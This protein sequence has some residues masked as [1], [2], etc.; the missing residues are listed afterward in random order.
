MDSIFHFNEEENQVKKGELISDINL[1]SVRTGT[2][3]WV[4]CFSPRFHVTSTKEWFLELRGGC[5]SK[6]K[7]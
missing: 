2:K 3:T 6:I 5:E 7:L 1:V 4:L